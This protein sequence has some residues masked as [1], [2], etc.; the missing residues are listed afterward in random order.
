VG[1]DIDKYDNT[2]TAYVHRNALSNNRNIYDTINIFDLNL[3]AQRHDIPAI[4]KSA[5]TENQINRVGGYVQDLA[6]LTSKLKVM[7]GLRYSYIESTSTVFTYKQNETVPTVGEPTNNYDYAFSPRFGIIYQ[8]IKDMSIFTS[9]SNSFVLNT[10]K[11]TSNSVLPPSLVDQFEV[12]VKNDL[13]NGLLSLNV[14]LYQIINGNAPQP[15]VPVN[16]K[17]PSAQQLAGEITSK[18]I[19]IDIMTKQINGFVFI[20]GYSYNDTRYTK[21]TQFVENSRLRYN[22]AHTANASVNYTFS[23]NLLNGL[24]VGIIGYYVGD[25]VAG[26]STQV[27]VANDTRK[28]MSVPDY[29]QFDATAGY[30][31]NACSVRVKLSNL[32]N[33][34]SYNVHDDNSVNPIAPRMFSATVAYKF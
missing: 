24:N 20:S 26:R 30:T 13:L 17:Y 3:T 5:V 10:A 34:L 19:E 14:T 33:E 7:A 32:L 6:S 15:I 28:L 1:M 21:S 22:P 27:Q 25:R 31:F 29:C 16:P 18:G 23:N 8:P 12:G 2:S 9:Y 11:D 4:D